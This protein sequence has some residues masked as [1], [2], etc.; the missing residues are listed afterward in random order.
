MHV[1]RSVRYFYVRCTRRLKRSW[2]KIKKIPQNLKWSGKVR[3]NIK[4]SHT[5]ARDHHK[6]SLAKKKYREQ[7][8]SRGIIDPKSITK[9]FFKDNSPHTK[10]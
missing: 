6:K 1:I 10:E 2:R 8:R 3:E 5:E 9:G 4:Q 7:R